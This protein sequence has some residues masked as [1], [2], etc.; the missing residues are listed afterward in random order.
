MKLVLYIQ[1]ILII[2]MI[3]GCGYT[4][5]KKPTNEVV[6]EDYKENIIE[7]SEPVVDIHIEEPVVPENITLFDM[8]GFKKDDFFISPINHPK[9]WTYYGSWGSEGIVE[10]KMPSGAYYKRILI[11]EDI[12]DIEH[13]LWRMTT[14]LYRRSKF[15]YEYYMYSH[16]RSI[17]KYDISH[18]KYVRFEGKASL[19]PIYGCGHNGSVEFIFYVDRKVLF[20]TGIIK[21]IDQKSPID[22]IFEIPDKSENLIIEVSSGNDDVGCDHWVIGDAKLFYIEVIEEK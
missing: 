1:I 4:I 17:V 10:Q 9:E 5:I 3:N 15:E 19:L 6:N 2:L 21:G 11:D 12:K 14:D 7:K 18:K 8:V 16:A 20:R 13:L 22:V